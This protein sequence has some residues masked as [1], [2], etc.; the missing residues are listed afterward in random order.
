[1]S[2][3]D[4]YLRVRDH[5]AGDFGGGPR[6][7]KFAWVVNLQKGGARPFVL[8][9]MWL[10]GDFGLCWLMKDRAFRCPG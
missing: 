3:L 2:F 5:L 1:M 9:L 7:L 10:T 8:W 4:R 6:L